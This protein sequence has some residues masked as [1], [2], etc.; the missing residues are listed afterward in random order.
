MFGQSK[1]VPFDPYRSRRSRWRPPRWLVLLL[2]GIALGAGGLL[3]VQ[4]RYLPPRLSAGATAELRAAYQSADAAR[5]RLTAELTQTARRLEATLAQNKGL[6]EELRA[7]RASVE[8]LRADLSTVVAALPPDPRGGPVEIRAARF[9]ANGAALN[10]DVL[11]TRERAGGKPIAGSMQFAVAGDSARG[12]PTTFTP[13]AA[14]VTIGAQQVVRG[15]LALP[16][17]LR[18]R[19]VTVQVLDRAGGRPIGMRVLR[20]Q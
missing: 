17:G 11:L 4:E 8:S 19:Q 2:I 18:P 3:F 16:E 1:P 14:A 12:A 15:S 20:V 7:S 13:P 6:A 10:Y 5:L 9:V